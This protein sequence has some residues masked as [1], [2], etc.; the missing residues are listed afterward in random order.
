MLPK[1][2]ANRF[3]HS[4]KNITLGIDGRRDFDYGNS[5]HLDILDGYDLTSQNGG[6]I[7]TQGV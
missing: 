6:Y 2:C 1:R 7:T 3:G 5:L 4:C